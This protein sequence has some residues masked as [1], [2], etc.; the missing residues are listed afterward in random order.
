ML[1]VAEA[2]ALKAAIH[3]V[4]WKQ[5]RFLPVRARPARHHGLPETIEAGSKGLPL[6]NGQR[7]RQKPRILKLFRG[8]DPLEPPNA[9]GAI[10]ENSGDS[11]VANMTQRSVLLGLFVVVQL[12]FL[13]VQNAF[14]MLQE[15]RLAACLRK[16]VIVQQIAPDWPDRKGHLWDFMEGSTTLT[17]RWSQATLQLQTWSLFA[18][19]VGKDCVFS[20]VAPVRR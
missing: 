13:I 18:P 3:P 6:L 4:G 17:N 19:N 20:V 2:Q 5:E 12:M 9:M 11:A 16:F 1:L 7:S 14:T 15:A 10:M 8:S